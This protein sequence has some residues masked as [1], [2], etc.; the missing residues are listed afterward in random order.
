MEWSGRKD[1]IHY[2]VLSLSK[3]VDKAAIEFDGEK[4]PERK[5][6][7]TVHGTIPVNVY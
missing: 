6:E 3:F 4:R 2:M 5:D 7:H 1:V